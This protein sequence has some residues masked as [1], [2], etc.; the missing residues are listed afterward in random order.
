ML[1]YLVVNYSVLNVLFFNVETETTSLTSTLC[2]NQNLATFMQRTGLLTDMILLNS[3]GKYIN[4]LIL[5][6]NLVLDL[7]TNNKVYFLFLVGCKVDMVM[8]GDITF[9][10]IS[11]LNFNKDG[12]I[13]NFVDSK[14][15]INQ[16]ILLV[17]R[18]GCQE[19]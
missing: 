4:F 3:I 6:L 10:Y 2:F 8:Y 7:W 17:S 18:F 14:L 19:D 11:H 15:E 13:L 9:G 16:F 12:L 1:F 5:T